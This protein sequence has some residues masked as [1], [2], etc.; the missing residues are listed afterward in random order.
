HDNPQLNVRDWSGR[1]PVRIVMDRYLK[2]STK[3][4]LFDRKQKTI[5]YNVL[6]HEEHE[7]LLLI[8]LDEKDFLQA[9]INDLAKQKIQSVIIEGGAATLAMFIENNLWDEARIF[10]SPQ[11]FDKGISAPRHPGILTEHYILA[12]DNLNIYRATH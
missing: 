3:L 12:G 8:R 6:K 1:D 11:K 7:N 10:I 2:L 9:L 5:C 4:H